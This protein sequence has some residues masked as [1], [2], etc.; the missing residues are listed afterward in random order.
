[1]LID[2][3]AV[4]DPFENFIKVMG[5]SQKHALILPQI[6]ILLYIGFAYLLKVI[7]YG[8]FLWW[9]IE[10]REEPK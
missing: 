4:I 9:K 10:K 1:M 3:G 6:K 2:L 5:P 8:P 7:M